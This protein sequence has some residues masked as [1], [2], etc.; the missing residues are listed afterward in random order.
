MLLICFFSSFCA[1]RYCRMISSKL[2][3]SQTCSY[4]EVACP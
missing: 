1:T 4:E 2:C 3:R